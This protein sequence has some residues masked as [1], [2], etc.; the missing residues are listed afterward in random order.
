MTDSTDPTGLVERVADLGFRVEA[1]ERRLAD[2]GA[3]GGAEFAQQF[4]ALNRLREEIA[5]H[6][7]PGGAA[8]LVGSVETPAGVRAEWQEGVAAGQLFEEDWT[9]LADALAALGNPVRLRLMK[10]LLEGHSTVAE[11]VELDGVGT[12]GQIYHHLRQLTAAGW[13]RGAGRGRYEVPVDRIVPLLATLL[14]AR[15]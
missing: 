3:T 7:L 6:E 13:L 1:L 9:E 15:R 11:L 2:A 12:T 5:R 8:M 10:A 14:A 4:W